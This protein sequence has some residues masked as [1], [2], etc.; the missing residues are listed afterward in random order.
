MALPVA[1]VAQMKTLLKDEA[2]AFFHSLNDSP[3]VSLRLNPAKAN[4]IPWEGLVSATVPWSSRGLYLSERPV[5]TFDPLFHAGHYYVQEA[6]SMF[7]EQA[8]KVALN[9]L[10][11]TTEPVRV[12]D[13]CAAPGGKS[14]LALT[15]LPETSLLVANEVVPSRATVLAENIIKWGYPNAIVTNND[16]ATIAAVL[17]SFFDVLLVDAPCSGE[18]LFRKD[19]DS[20]REWAPEHVKSCSLRQR[21]ILQAALTSLKPGGFVVYST[22]TYN[23]EENE[24]TVKWLMDQW[25]LIPYTVPVDDHW[26]VRPSLNQQLPTL[27]VHRFL[28]HK[29]K[30]EG[31]FLSLLQLPQDAVEARQPYVF[32]A[33]DVPEKKRKRGKPPVSSS[34]KPATVVAP[35]AM[36]ACLK[37]P[38][39]FD[40]SINRKGCVLAVPSF[41]SEDYRYLSQQLNVMH[42]GINIGEWKGKDFVPH[43]SLAL[44]V[45]FN[46]TAVPGVVVDRKQAIAFL[47]RE[48]LT[49]PSDCSLGWVL[50]LYENQPLGW[51]KNI[52][53]RANNYWPVEWR[54]RS[55][56]PF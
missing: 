22:C 43:C 29:T 23:L 14:T 49:L 34:H 52:G 4:A 40:W 56:N 17:P 3:P 45:A 38:N 54:I 39:A 20:I 37:N 7:V 44:S 24:Y 19:P 1:F 9:H 31:F 50:I 47:R 2:D 53:Q 10:E 35:D 25:H 28:P 13:L 26:G 5:F 33:I 55:D 51:V 46:K 48:S 18:G 15:L 21:S 32:E 27:P 8:L 30:G 12:L 36:R 42:A 16:P 41:L 6:S 11:Q